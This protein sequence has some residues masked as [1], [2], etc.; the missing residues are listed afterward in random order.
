[1]LEENSNF[2]VRDEVAVEDFGSNSLLFFCEQRRMLE[3]NS[4][5]QKVLALLDGRRELKQVITEYSVYFKLSERQA[6]KDVCHAIQYFLSEGAIS[7]VLTGDQG[8]RN[9]AKN[10][11]AIYRANPNVS[12]RESNN[13]AVLFEI[14]SKK[15]V[16]INKIGLII[17][18]FMKCYPRNKFEI[19]EYLKKNYVGIK[20]SFMISDVERFLIK[21]E[22][23]KLLIKIASD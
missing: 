22:K 21:L 10:E 15:L 3:L 5:S 9:K 12:L 16:H 19:V 8:K 17:W 4:S 23:D 2:I 7:R 11:L 6:K 1:M 13:G 20:S 14:D 18:N